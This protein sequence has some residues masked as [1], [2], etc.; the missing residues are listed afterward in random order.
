MCFKDESLEEFTTE[1]FPKYDIKSLLDIPIYIGGEL[2]NI[3]C[4]EATHE[5]RYWTNEDINFSKLL[6]K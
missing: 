6:P 3:L 2:N 1:Y 4:F 5:L